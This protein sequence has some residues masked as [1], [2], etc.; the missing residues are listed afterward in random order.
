MHLIKFFFSIV[1]HYKEY[2]ELQELPYYQCE[3]CEF[4]TE[5]L[6]TAQKHAKSSH[7][8]ERRWQTKLIKSME[9]RPN[10][11]AL[12]EDHSG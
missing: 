10:S 6:S 9:D 3:R 12:A 7:G 11:E 1:E 8:L 2:H 4:V 5:K